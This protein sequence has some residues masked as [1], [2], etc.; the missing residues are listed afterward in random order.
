LAPIDASSPSATEQRPT[1]VVTRTAATEFDEEL[2]VEA[3]ALMYSA[4]RTGG[5]RHLE[6][7]VIG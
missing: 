6:S 7:L 2:F 4:K 3:D 5:D 1:R